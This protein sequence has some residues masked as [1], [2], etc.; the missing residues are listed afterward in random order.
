MTQRRRLAGVGLL[1]AV[2]VGCS[3]DSSEPAVTLPN[4]AADAV[5][6][7]LGSYEIGG[8]PDEFV[9]GPRV[10]VYGDGAVFAEM[11]DGVVSFRLVTGRLDE[12]QL[13]EV[14]EAAE[15]LPAE[16]VVGQLPSDGVPLLLV[17]GDRR[18]DIGDPAIEPFG[19]FVAKLT[20][21]VDAAATDEWRPARWIMQPYEA[22]CVVVPDD[23][24]AGP[25]DAPV[26]PHL[27][28]TYL[29]G[30]C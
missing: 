14:F 21:M 7:Q 15:E 12:S 13:V 25:Y 10:V 4:V 8:V 20:S 5:L 9:V 3:S 19:A 2:A 18:W 27:M 6:I 24:E 28:D 29:L 1:I 22:P 23:P 17:I 30:E 16:G 26:Y 11:Y